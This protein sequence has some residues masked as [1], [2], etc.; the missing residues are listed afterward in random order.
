[1][2]RFHQAMEENLAKL[3]QFVPIVARVHGGSHP[4]F[5]DVHRIF[6]AMHEKIQAAGDN[7]PDLSTEFHKLREITQNYSVP[8]DVCE[9][10]AA[11]YNI[12]AELDEAYHR[13]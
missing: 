8:R 1:M 10:Y 9:T 2:T 3:E 11:V 4:E 12:L 7:K 5:H 6:A 13:E